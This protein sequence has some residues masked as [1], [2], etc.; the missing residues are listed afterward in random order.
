M[1][2]VKIIFSIN[3]THGSENTRGE[4]TSNS[5]IVNV[6]RTYA[7]TTAHTHP[8]TGTIENSIYLILCSVNKD[9]VIFSRIPLGILALILLG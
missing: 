8:Y 7:R 3:M 2:R 4:H 9:N 5:M 6:Q 1:L